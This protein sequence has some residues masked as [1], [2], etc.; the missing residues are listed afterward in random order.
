VRAGITQIYVPPSAAAEAAA[1]P[2][3]SV[4][5]VRDLE[6]C[7]AVLTGDGS[8]APFEPRPPRADQGTLDL[9]DVRG[10]EL[11]RFGL[12][13]AAAGN[14]HMCF[15][16]PPGIGKTLLA[17]RLPSVLPDLADDR[18][19]EVTTI[20]SLAGTLAPGS[21]LVRRP[22]FQAPHHSASQAALLGTMRQHHVV[23]GAVTL[24]HGGVL[25]LDEAPEFPRPT[26]EGLRQPLESGTVS[27][28][29]AGGSVVVPA[30]VQ[31]VLAANPCP[32]G[33][34]T[35]D[36]QHCTCTPLAKRRYRSKLSGPLL[37]RID[38]RLRLTAPSINALPG[39]ASAPVAARV[40]QARE[41]AS[42][43][44]RHE[45]W[46]WNRNIPSKRLRSD[47]APDDRGSAFLAEH[48]RMSMRGADRVA[49]LAWT[50]CDLRR[51]SRPNH[52]DVAT[53][54]ALRG[55]DDLG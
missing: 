54:L 2:G 13:V 25:F 15:I 3:A 42:T 39:E 47:F 9:G 27:I 34:G 35:D 30:D 29:R 14:H 20:A 44:F 8:G 41:M 1:I 43:R 23:A 16:G 11:A 10:H 24:A 53:A 38:V 12:E 7:R 33:L 51:G 22:P 6:H 26:L 28:A 46:S 40:E 21:G 36:G 32:C 52:D 55:H 5:A 50:I 4:V 31:V 45:P 37:D 17:E 19:I 48:D 49:R 18:A